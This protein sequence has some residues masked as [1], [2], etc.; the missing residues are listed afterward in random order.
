MKPSCTN[1]DRLSKLKQD[2][3]KAE[4]GELPYEVVGDIMEQ[5]ERVKAE[6]EKRNE[7]VFIL[8]FW[9]WKSI[10]IKEF[11]H[12]HAMNE[13]F[14]KRIKKEKDNFPYRKKFKYIVYYGQKVNINISKG[15]EG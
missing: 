13:W 12:E 14:A 3:K 7:K 11:S 6:Y 1:A 4:S 5:I 8:I 15:G 9:G 2:L 10:D